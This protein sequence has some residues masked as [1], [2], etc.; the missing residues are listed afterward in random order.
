MKYL[1]ILLLVLS[2]H[3]G[4]AQIKIFDKAINAVKKGQEVINILKNKPADKPTNKPVDKPAEKTNPTYK[5]SIPAD[6][7]P[8]EFGLKDIHEYAKTGNNQLLLSE[9]IEKGIYVDIPTQR[10]TGEYFQSKSHLTPLMIAVQNGKIET[11][12]L[13]LLYGADPTIKNADNKSAFD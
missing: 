1:S 9:C 12:R 5:K 4:M 10:R 13:L 8:K 3:I 6:N 11:C 2:C 7:N